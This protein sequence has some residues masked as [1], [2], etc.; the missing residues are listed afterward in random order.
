MTEM[1]S[2]FFPLFLHITEV[3]QRFALSK[4]FKLYILFNFCGTNFVSLII[5]KYSF[6]TQMANS[7]LFNCGLMFRHQ[8]FLVL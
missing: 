5:F 2:G 8:D 7:F 6:Q 4:V 3:F 1:Q